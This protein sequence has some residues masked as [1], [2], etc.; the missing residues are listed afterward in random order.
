MFSG[1]LSLKLLLEKPIRLNSIKVYVIDTFV[2]S[3]WH[4]D[5]LPH[6]PLVLISVII[7]FTGC[8]QEGKEIILTADQFQD[9]S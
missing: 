1:N 6:S 4:F 7:T 9:L 3:D 2:K 8:Y 5:W